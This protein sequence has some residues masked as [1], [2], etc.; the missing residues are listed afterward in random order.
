MPVESSGGPG[1]SE[2]GWGVG[3]L[4]G[5]GGRRG[6]GDVRRVQKDITSE[7]TSAS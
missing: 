1:L 7:Q 6:E 5:R 4:S 2:A 3:S